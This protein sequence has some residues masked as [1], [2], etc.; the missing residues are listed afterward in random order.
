MALPSDNDV[1]AA[2]ATGQG[3]AGI[4]IV[5]ISGKNLS[6]LARALPCDTRLRVH[7]LRDVD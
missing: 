1:I 7:A 2:I 4:G 5:R 3:R 6:G